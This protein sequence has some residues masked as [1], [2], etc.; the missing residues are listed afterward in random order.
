MKPRLQPWMSCFTFLEFQCPCLKGGCEN[1]RQLGSCRGCSPRSSSAASPPAGTGPWQTPGHECRE[2]K[3]S[4]VWQRRQRHGAPSV[5]ESSSLES[6]WRRIKV[7][8]PGVPRLYSFPIFSHTFF[9]PKISAGVPEGAANE[10]ELLGY[11]PN[12][13]CP[14]GSGLPWGRFWVAAWSLWQNY[15][16]QLWWSYLPSLSLS[17][18]LSV[19]MGWGDKME[20][21]QGK[22]G[23]IK[24]C[25][26]KNF[27]NCKI[28]Q[29]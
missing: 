11:T 17:D 5:R 23:R 12:C 1:E 29:S 10:A 24:W 4:L 16:E 6:V 18:F 20:W 2:R 26:W 25:S 9:W 3:E 19:G 22:A 13:P 7:M 15:S 21:S 8:L 28:I 14:A 27:V